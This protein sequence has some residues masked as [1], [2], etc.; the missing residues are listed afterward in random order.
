MSS[1]LGVSV[2]LQ[3]PQAALQQY[4]QPPPAGPRGLQ[5]VLQRARQASCSRGGPAPDLPWGEKAQNCL[6]ATGHLRGTE[7]PCQHLTALRKCR[8]SLA[9]V[10]SLRSLLVQ[11]VK[12][13]KIYKC[14]ISFSATKL[15]PILALQIS[16]LLSRYETICG[17]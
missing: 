14:R 17:F 9:S 10:R 4:L 3:Q 12:P 13:Q 8:L 1:Q 15:C 7:Q 6:I 16:S 11:V 2:C 5:L